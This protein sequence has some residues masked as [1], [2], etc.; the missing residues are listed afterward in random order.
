MLTTTFAQNC[1][2]EL[3]DL[4]SKTCTKRPTGSI[5]MTVKNGSGN[6]NFKWDD[7]ETS[8]DRFNL[9][10]GEYTV[11]V[12][13]ENG[14]MVTKS[15]QIITHVALESTI[16][17]LSS[18]GNTDLKL[19]FDGNEIPESITWINSS[20][21]LNTQNHRLISAEPGNYN[22]ILLDKHHCITILKTEVK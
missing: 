18:D 13:D 16:N 7:G 5:G 19:T 17:V 22:V 14:C 4:V 21:V 20:G 9:K 11:T 8:R 2:L 1:K 6:Y 12:N 15:F 10:K 3:V